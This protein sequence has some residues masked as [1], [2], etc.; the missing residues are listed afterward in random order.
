MTTEILPAPYSRLDPEITA[1]MRRRLEEA[2]ATKTQSAL[3]YILFALFGAM[4]LVA[5]VALVVTNSA[6][7]RQV[8]NRVAE[9]IAA[10][11]V[12]V[13]VMQT[14]R[15]STTDAVNA[16]ALMLL[17]IKPSTHE[18]AITSIPRDLWIRLGQY[19]ERRLGTAPAVGKAAG[20]PGEGAGLT[21]DTIQRS[22]GQPVHAYV[23]VDRRDLAKAVDAVGGIDVNIPQ[24]FFEY[25]TRERF[26]RGARHLDGDQA[27]LYADSPWILGPANDRFARELRQRQVLAALVAK[28][29][30]S[31]T[32]AS[33]SQFGEQ[34]N[35][36]PQQVAWLRKT[37][38]G[39]L[40]RGV[41]LAPY[42]DTFEVATMADTGEAVRPH[43][44]T[45]GQIRATV[46]NVFAT[47]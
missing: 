33:S 41:T 30:V 4:I 19:G 16:D 46:A 24:S 43:D 14:F 37:M 29:S 27:L 31:N 6:A 28:A 17:S 35:L 40:A 26:L 8:P 18:A 9:G 36:T 2:R 42:M 22:F 45:F 38:R 12:N 34:T 32:A 13:L 21:A 11:R 20:Y 39:T 7:F 47:R 3:E 1:R 44:P 10:D 15:N 23:S 25:K 5:A